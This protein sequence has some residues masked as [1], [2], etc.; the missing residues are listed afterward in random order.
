MLG[1]QKG[2]L[3]MC[4]ET[5]LQQEEPSCAAP[6]QICKG[7]GT[8]GGQAGFKLVISCEANGKKLIT[9]IL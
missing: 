9:T 8:H 4:A 7:E 2:L 6:P 3:E 5:R 1:R